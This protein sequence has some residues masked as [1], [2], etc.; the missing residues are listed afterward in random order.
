MDIYDPQTLGFMVF[1]GF[2]VI[3]AI[4]IALVS[5]FSMKETS[6][7]EALAKQRKELQKTQPPRVEKKKKDKPSEKRGR[8]KKKEDKPNG[9]LPEPEPTP[10]AS[11]TVSESEPE[12]AP[13]PMPLVTPAPPAPPVPVAPEPPVVAVAHAP[14]L[15]HQPAPSPKDKKKREKKVAKV[16]PAPSPASASAATSK[17][18]PVLEAVTKEVPVM[19]V[20]P[21]GAQ[22]SSPVAVSSPS[23][24]TEA[25]AGHDE[26]KHDGPS[27]KKVSS[28]KKAEPLEAPSCVAGWG[29]AGSPGPTLPQSVTCAKGPVQETLQCHSEPQSIEVGSVLGSRK[30]RGTTA[31]SLEHLQDPSSAP[32]G[33]K[34]LHR[35]CMRGCYNG[36]QKAQFIL[37]EDG[38]LEEA[39]CNHSQKAEGKYMMAT[40]G[41]VCTCVRNGGGWSRPAINTVESV[42]INC[43]PTYEGKTK[44]A[45]TAYLAGLQFRRGNAVSAQGLCAEGVGGRALGSC[46]TR[47]LA[48]SLSSR[49]SQQSWA[50]CLHPNMGKKHLAIHLRPDGCLKCYGCWEGPRSWLR[51]VE[52]EYIL[53]RVTLQLSKTKKNGT[54]SSRAW[55]CPNRSEGGLF[56][57]LVPSLAGVADGAGP[58]HDLLRT[59]DSQSQGLSSE[60]G[61]EPWTR[62]VTGQRAKAV[63]IQYKKSHACSSCSLQKRLS[64]WSCLV[65]PVAPRCFCSGVKGGVCSRSAAAAD[66]M[67]APLYLPYKTLLSTVSNMVFSEGEAQRLIEILT[68]KAGII[69]DTWHTAT[70]K[71]D[72]VA[73][74]K[75]QLEEKE[76]QLSAEQ[77]DVAAAKNKLRELS[78]ELHAE[79]SKTASVEA[80]LKEQLS[81][82]D[83]EIAALQAR[84]Q[85]S[86]QDHVKET[87]QLNAKIQSLQEQLENGP[88]AQLARLQQEN[89]ILRDALNQAT[90]QTESKQN[91]ELAKLRQECSKLSKEL[92]EKSEALQAEE[93][94]RKSLDTKVAAFEKQI[95]QLQSSQADSERTL[96]KRLDEVS[97]ELRKSQ[98]SSS[99]LQGELEKANQ[100]MASIAALQAKVSSAEAEVKDRC[101]QVESLQSQLS[102]VSVEKTRLEERILSIEA[103]LE[104]SQRKESENEK[105]IQLTKAAEMEQLQSSLKEKEHQVSALEKEVFQ[106]KEGLEQQ[107]M[108]NNDLR[109]KNWEAIEALASS[110]KMCEEKLSSAQTAK[111]AAEQLLSRWQTETKEALQMLFPQ[112]PIDTEQNNWLLE[113]KQKAQ[114]ALNKKTESPVEPLHELLQKLK[115]AEESQT[116]LQAECEQYRS[117]LAETE[118]MLKD[119]QRSVEQEELVWRA[120]I[121]ESEEELKK[122]QEQ[123]QSLEAAVQRLKL[124]SQSTEQLKEQVM[125]LEAQLEKQLESANSNSQSYCEEVAQLKDLLSES[126]S[127]LDVAKL[128]T[129]KQSEELALVRQHLREMKEHMQDGEAAGTRGEVQPSQLQYKLTQTIENLESEQ[130]LRQQLSEEFEQAQKSVSDLQAELDA[131]KVAG[132]APVSDTDDV[133]QLKERLEKEKKLTNDLGQAATKLQQLLRATQEQLAKEKE[134]VRTLQEQFQGEDKNEGLKEGTSV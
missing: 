68:D 95:S 40:I 47:C 104:A 57:P 8:S 22:Q 114:E 132:E 45:A 35:S 116:T 92:S 46:C 90:S 105:E 43:G 82:R 12:P 83:Q 117:V 119:L 86:Y 89:S 109:V 71:G 102:Q 127:Q 134:T 53:G 99:S 52:L 128:D 65:I 100:E 67:D 97:E 59:A 66:T 79:K 27:K 39:V 77:E 26:A 84:M 13:V 6:Y 4:G 125:L 94:Q 113:F 60:E 21:V 76:K 131:L 56:V 96:Q 44:N 11:E 34:R 24:K 93:Q 20:P 19:A 41:P 17:S 54:Q 108:K 106:L 2:M 91:A 33:L 103:L 10:E 87:Q 5:T 38:L 49:G 31:F 121:A 14:V 18:A 124:E 16:E 3:S 80:R 120:K 63:S 122:A 111:D 30:G 88:N 37:S 98:S 29:Y 9:K 55:Q 51:A 78:K 25:V 58:R 107:K 50:L 126:Q 110:E 28:K 73:A 74:L 72:P 115:E 81:S 130:A 129:Q 42:T 112:I 64:Q 85:A 1:G 48:R 15:E 23:K 133:V 62:S 70:Q 32:T 123:I 7:E 118:G 101:A 69:Q 75:R 61:A 36:G